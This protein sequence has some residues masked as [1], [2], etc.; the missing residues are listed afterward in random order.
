MRMFRKEKWYNLG[1]LTPTG[2]CVPTGRSVCYPGQDKGVRSTGMQHF[3][4][5]SLLVQLL[6]V[7]LLFVV[8]VLIGGVVVNTVGEQ[9][10]STD[11]QAS[12]QALAQEIALETGLHLRD[13]ENALIMLGKLAAKVDTPDAMVNTFQAWKAA[14]NDVDYVYWLDSVGQI[15][16]S[17]PQGK[18]GVG[19]EFSPP[20]VVQRTLMATGPVFEVGM[21]VEPTLSSGVIIAEPVRAASGTLV[22][23]VAASLSLKELS[24]PL[25]R[26]VL[27]QQQ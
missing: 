8:V 23:I 1:I 15:R 18:G 25:Q 2:R 6:S 11:V 16:V 3:V 5:R 4:R 19:S 22:G 9:Q 21:A 12:D 20:R 7:Y 26:V 10:L 27:A 14:R 13:A 17:W 24:E